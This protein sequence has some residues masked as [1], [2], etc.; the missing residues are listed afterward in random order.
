MGALLW[1]LLAMFRHRAGPKACRA[2]APPLRVSVRQHLLL[3][4]RP[5]GASPVALVQAVVGALRRSG[6]RGGRRSRLLWQDFLRVLSALF[7]PLFVILL[8]G[9][10]CN[11]GGGLMQHLPDPSRPVLLFKKKNPVS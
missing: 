10:I 5:S 1:R 9:S 2:G 3:S 11:F 8:F 4:V 7:R 6:V